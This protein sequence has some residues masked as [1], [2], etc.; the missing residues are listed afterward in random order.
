MT[1]RSRVGVEEEQAQIARRRGAVMVAAAALDRAATFTT[2]I[3]TE[4]A[5]GSCGQ[6]SWCTTSDVSTSSAACWVR[7][8]VTSGR[9]ARRC[10][11]WPGCRADGPRRR[12]SGVEKG[13]AKTFVAIADQLLAGGDRD[14]ACARSYRSPIAVGG[15]TDRL[16][17][18][19]YVV[20][21]AERIGLP[22]RPPYSRDRARRSGD[23]GPVG[24]AASE[25]LRPQDMADP[26]AAMYVGI[27]A[28]KAGDFT[29]GLGP[30]RAR[31]RGYRTR[32]GSG[33]SPRRW[34]TTPGCQLR[35]RLRSR[36]G[37]RRRGRNPGPRYTPAAIRTNRTAR[38]RAGRCAAGQRN[39]PRWD[40]CR[41]EA[42]GRRCAEADARSRP[43]QPRAPPPARRYDD[44]FRAL[45][46]V[47]NED[48]PA[49]DSLCDGRRAGPRRGR[50]GGKH[51]AQVA[52]VTA[53]L[54]D[55]VRRSEPPI[56][57]A[58]LVCARPLMSDDDNAEGLFV[59]ALATNRRATHSS[60]RGRSSRSSAGCV[61]ADEP[62]THESP[63]R[64]AMNLF[65]ALRTRWS[66]RACQE[67]RATGERIGPRTPARSADRLTAQEATDRRTRGHR[68]VQSR[69]R[70]ATRPRSPNHR[71][72]PLPDLPES[73]E[74]PPGHNCGSCP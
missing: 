13:A 73:S 46:P 30:W 22:G 53:E 14:A 6:P 38:R 45:W 36:P 59:A 55:V 66:E 9:S 47:F 62:R 67:L 15:P 32:A 63:L 70:R 23:H 39:R 52:K 71:I 68:P 17:T 20:D 7:S 1:T 51:A 56:L 3:R 57:R 28:E 26:V 69:N 42:T 60:A 19:Q 4:R 49:I 48:D 29:A 58:G 37:V 12:R 31:S 44:V 40:A 34:S 64:D 61:G 24:T 10:S 33:C 2:E 65:D 16:R 74:S 11:H 72:A 21:A 43:P 5:S 25:R 54:E 50:G 8:G 27:A 35:R 41:T 18:R